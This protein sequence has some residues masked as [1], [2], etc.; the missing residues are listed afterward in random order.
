MV[1]ILMMVI[2]PLLH[3]ILIIPLN[4]DDDDDD[5]TD[6]A[7]VAIGIAAA[8][9]DDDDDDNQNADCDVIGAAIVVDVNAADDGDTKYMFIPTYVGASLCSWFYFLL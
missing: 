5:V 9:N 2:M 6:A 8:A 4:V 1:M 7:N 3:Q